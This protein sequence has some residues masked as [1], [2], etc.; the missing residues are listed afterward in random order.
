MHPPDGVGLCVYLL[1]RF[2]VRAGDRLI[3]DQSWPRRKAKALLK[4]LALN[5]GRWLHREQVLETLWPDL[6]PSAAD[7]NLRQ[8]LHYVRQAFAAHGLASPVVIA[9]H[10]TV[11]L[12]REAWVDTEAFGD[13]AAAARQTRTDPALYESALDVFRG[14]LLPEDIY[15]DWTQLQREELK[16]LHR[17]LVF[18]LARLEE[19]RGR[20]DAAIRGLEE[21]VRLDAL[22][23]SAHRA[24][25]RLLAESG[26]RQRAARQYNRCRDA[27]AE[28]LGVEPSEETQALHQ[29]VIEGSLQRLA[30]PITATGVFIGREREMGILTGGLE[31]ARAGRGRCFMLVGEAGIG[32]TR[33]AEELDLNARLSGAEVLW[34]RC[35]DGEGAPAYWP[36]VQAIRS[37]AERRSD[38]EVVA[39]ART[40]IRDVAALVPELAR[41]LQDTAASSLPADSD[42]ARFRL[43]ESVAGLFMK[44]AERQP[45][46]LILDDLHIADDATL[47]LVE[48]LAQ[49]LP[50]SRLLLLGSYRDSEVTPGSRLH[51]TLGALERNFPGHSIRLEGLSAQE[52]ARLMGVSGGPGAEKRMVAT[53]HDQTGGNPFLIQELTNVLVAAGSPEWSLE[54]PGWS[55]VLPRGAQAVIFRSLDRLSGSCREVLTQASVIGQ[56]FGLDVLR[57]LDGLQEMQ[58]LETLGEAISARV[59]VQV[60]GGVGRFR[61]SHSLLRE[62]LYSKLRIARR[63]VLHRQVGEALEQL[64]GPDSDE[65]LEEFA[66]HFLEAV[67]A[68]EARRAGRYARLAGDRAMTLYAYEEAARFYQKALE[69]SAHEE[70]IDD[71]LRCDLLLSL[72]QA[73]WDAGD[74]EGGRQAFQA[75]AAAARKRGDCS[76]LARAALGCGR[77][78]TSFGK[79]DRQLVDLLEEALACLPAEDT[80]LRAM[81]SACLARS[82][83]WSEQDERRIDLS[84][85]AVEVARRTGDR[86]ALA[87]VLDAAW[88]ALW[89]PENP[90][91]RLDLATEMLRLADETADKA[92]AHQGHRWRMIALLEIGDVAEARR[93]FDA[94]VRI[95]QELQQ[96]AQL[97]NASVVAAMWAQFEG[98]FDEAEQLA[99]EALASAERAHDRAAAE[100]FG[101]QMIALLRERGR[102]H[103]IEPT[104]KAFVEQ[105]P[106]V[107][108]WRSVLAWIYSQKGREPEARTEFE[109]LA[110]DDFACLHRDYT[111]LMATSLLADVCSFLKDRSR[112][113][114]LYEQLLPFA[115]RN[116]VMG[117]A[118]VC[119]GSVS[120]SLGVLATAMRRWR[121]GEQHF[122]SAL[123]MNERMGARPWLAWSQHDFARMLTDR[124]KPGDRQRAECLL[125]G[126]LA[127]A[128]ELG[129]TA[130]EETALALIDRKKPGGPLP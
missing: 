53:V 36:W 99:K 40:G 32:K 33:T 87:Y 68:G 42:Q 70:P 127:S 37:Y 51:R 56:E 4:L 121:E 24:L 126:A 6:E 65:H 59:L 30:K 86:G 58:L 114:I 119:A 78:L 45:V 11:A 73:K 27:L 103:E 29:S 28:E 20:P 48:F 95:A 66:F 25:I 17:Q 21:I 43:F 62:G 122:E 80:P 18:E 125:D 112:A 60:P 54:E 108:A 105:N 118:I 91:A 34:G 19:F 124:D 111:W 7:H 63:S 128:R 101:A 75:G 64:Y 31:D 96:P 94:Q 79:T 77:S 107:V 50:R 8:N 123:E 38:Q 47:L 3:I 67:P 116:I 35:Y 88:I 9:A 115:G 81:L 84:R 85:Q 10:S 106:A 55:I 52:V 13:R 100:Q 72:G 129:M 92:R 93:E 44:A 12:A 61:F 90:A 26:D 113:A 49:Q 74:P 76:Q 117:Y 22:D 89:V 83:Y 39:V 82:L 16:A 41:L 130:L 14:D 23:E 71:G 1:G 57:R 110:P 5:R 104:V 2:E 46:V 98:R 97:E 109:R 120:R 15:E 69:T 102:L